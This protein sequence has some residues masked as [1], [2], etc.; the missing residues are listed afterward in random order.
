MATATMLELIAIA[1]GEETTAAQAAEELE[2]R[3]HDLAIDPD[4]IG[5]IICERD[6]SFR[7]MTKR[8]PAATVTW[9][10]FWGLLLEVVMEDWRETG[11]DRAF[12]KEVRETLTPGSSALFMVVTAAQGRDAIDAVSQYRGRSLSCSLAA[13]GLA[14]LRDA[15]NGERSQGE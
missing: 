1:F 8:R 2:R 10:K 4:A 11:I 14:E 7:L 5:V 13:R 3:S 6:A 9:S 12:R 15:L